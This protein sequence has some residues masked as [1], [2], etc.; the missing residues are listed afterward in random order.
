VSG[1]EKSYLLYGGSFFRGGNSQREVN[2]AKK[3]LHD[4]SIEKKGNLRLGESY[5]GLIQKGKFLG[6]GL[7]YMCM[8]EE[9][10]IE[11][12]ELAKR[13]YPRG[14][15]NLRERLTAGGWS[16]HLYIRLLLTW[17]EGESDIGRGVRVSWRGL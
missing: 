4:L 7:T 12:K 2:V 5:G 14:G 3:N 16:W 15:Q 6:R 17:G 9:K 11:K 1:G 8:V 10:K 13:D